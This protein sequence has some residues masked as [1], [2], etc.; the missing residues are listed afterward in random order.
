M[1]INPVHCLPASL[2]ACALL[3]AT[4]ASLHA[5][6]AY[7]TPCGY[8]QTTLYAKATGYL[9]LGVHPEALVQ[10]TL[11]E[12]NITISGNKVTITDPDVNFNDLM[13][14]NSAYVLV[15]HF[16]N[17]VI[18][19]PL[20]RDG[21]KKPGAS[22]TEHSIKVDDRLLSDLVNK[23]TPPDSYVLR[24]ARTLDD[25]LGE[26]NQFGLKSGSAMSADTVN[27]FNSATTKLAAYYSGNE[28]RRR[29]STE[30]IGNMPV[31]SHEPLTITRKAGS[32]VT[33]VVIGEVSLK[34]QKLVVPTFNSLLHT[35]LPLSQTLAEIALQLLMTP[36]STF[37][38]MTKMP[39]SRSSTT[40]VPGNVRTMERMFP[41]S[42]SAEFFPST[43]NLPRHLPTSRCPA[44]IKP[45]NNQPCSIAPFSPMLS[46]PALSFL[47]KLP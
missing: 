11:E 18:A 6:T 13:N 19:L 41:I 42:P 45:T 17:E 29:G 16:G 9:G 4:I 21:W 40:T 47:E 23:G 10:H 32:D 31:F 30:N 27:I 7:S 39:W 28:W 33:A 34:N 26:D 20:N 5:E 3:P 44:N 12:G 36:S 38:Q 24:K 43:T 8:I 1:F 22:W 25:I 46:P 37:P 35:R 2:C 14:E 15:L